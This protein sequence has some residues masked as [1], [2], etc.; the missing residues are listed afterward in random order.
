MSYSHIVT[1][2]TNCIIGIGLT[3]QALC[4]D[5]S[6]IKP[7]FQIDIK[8]QQK[9]SG[10]SASKNLYHFN[11][12]LYSDSKTQNLY[13][14][15]VSMGGVL[16]GTS[17]QIAALNSACDPSNSSGTGATFVVGFD[18]NGAVICG[19]PGLSNCSGTDF[20]T[21][22][23]ADG[24]SICTA[25]CSPSSPPSSPVNCVGGWGACDAPGTC[26]TTG[27]RTYVITT[28]ASNGGSSCAFTA[29]AQ[30]SCSTPACYTNCTAAPC[31]IAGTPVL[32]ADGKYKAI[33]KVQA[34]DR[35]VSYDEHRQTQR[36]DK[37]LYPTS[38]KEQWQRLHHF[39]LAD[40]TK[41]TSN[42]I[43]P[44][45]VVEKDYWFEASEI[46]SMFKQGQSLSM[47]NVKGEAVLIKKLW[48]EHKKVPVYNL[49]VNG[50]AL[51]DEKYGKW[52]RGHNYYVKGILTHN[53][54]APSSCPPQNPWDPPVTCNECPPGSVLDGYCVQC[55]AGKVYRN[56]GGTR[57]CC[58]PGPGMELGIE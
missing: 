52:G 29:G 34:G 28:P 48:V 50:I 55:P 37:V 54:L 32:M 35:I 45:Y 44:F 12:S 22:F 26:G 9:D 5:A 1:A 42:S 33:E 24:T 6:C 27:K 31:F 21:G 38:H 11:V 43:H 41:L 20:L 57:Q 4:F 8:F 18:A 10:K 46:S 7:Q 3:W 56:N 58:V 15:C 14:V 23:N 2:N 13:D 17:C 25:G 16:V 49:E 53:K 39:E 47:L 40:G 30:Q 51:Q 36:V 19:Q